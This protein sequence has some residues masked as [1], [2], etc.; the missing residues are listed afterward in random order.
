MFFQAIFNLL[1]PMLISP[2]TFGLFSIMIA[3]ANFA[4]LL[5]SAGI[6]SLLSYNASAQ[7]QS[8]AGIQQL[9]FY[10]TT[11]QFIVILIAEV[12]RYTN[13]HPFLIWPS[14]QISAGIGGIILFL[15]IAHTEKLSAI[16]TGFLRAGNF[17]LLAAIVGFIQILLLVV[18]FLFKRP[19]PATTPLYIII[20]ANIF[21][22]STIHI[23]LYKK[24]IAYIYN[25]TKAINFNAGLL[26]AFPAY[27]ANLIQFMAT[28][29][30][31]WLIDYWYDKSQVGF[32]A[33]SNQLG[34]ILMLVPFVLASIAFPMLSN[35]KIKEEIF[36]KWIR[37]MNGVI[38]IILLCA[39]LLSPMLIRLLWN[40]RYNDSIVPFLLI[41][42]G[43]F[44]RAQIA[45]YA[46]YFA[47]KRK[48]SVNVWTSVIALFSMVLADIILLPIWQIR[49][50]AIGLSIAQILSA[51]WL[52]KQFNMSSKTT[53][54]RL[55]PLKDDFKPTLFRNPWK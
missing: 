13:G 16:F 38:W 51:V 33:L 49:G 44:A 7:S 40:N 48:I 52:I 10:S 2:D 26:Y 29:I 27:L 9:L 17:F 54:Y 42:P 34:Q 14:D 23:R 47:A 3:N 6:P 20:A 22:V 21:L 4:V 39:L 50:A 32:Y 46:A 37:L 19:G 28:R 5:T 15:C 35:E 45:V 31:L 55:W 8:F 41:L 11:A 1:L 53:G 36:A 24:P 12:I 43:F 25:K 18:W 30:D